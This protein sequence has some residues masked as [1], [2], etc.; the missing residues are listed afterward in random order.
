MPAQLVGSHASKGKQLT[1]IDRWSHPT[2]GFAEQS[3]L[4]NFK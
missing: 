3:G 4:G 1:L 2:I